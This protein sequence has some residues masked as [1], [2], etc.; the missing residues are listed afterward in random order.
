MDVGI[1][2][3]EC[4]RGRYVITR[5]SLTQTARPD[6]PTRG[7]SV[8]FKTILMT[9][10]LLHTDGRSSYTLGLA[11]KLPRGKPSHEHTVVL[12]FRCDKT[13]PR[14]KTPIVSIEAAI[15]ERHRLRGLNNRHGFLMVPETGKDPLPA[16]LLGPPFVERGREVESLSVFFSVYKGINPIM[17]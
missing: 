3:G 16:F 9:S 1:L 17:T 10:V 5:W 7:L 14:D 6:M 13:P 4:R 2:I 8:F 15:T 11:S 12:S